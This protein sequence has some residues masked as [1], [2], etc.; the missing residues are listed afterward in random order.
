MFV[1]S[2]VCA[3]A[4]ILIVDDEEM[5]RLLER[6]CLEDAG[7]TPFFA[8]DGEA[9]LQVY[10]D[11]DIDVVVTDLRM[12]NLDGLQLIQQ[13]L[14]INPGAAV[15]AVSGAAVDQLGEAEAVTALSGLVTPIQ[16]DQLVEAVQEALDTLDQDVWGV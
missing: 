14:E 9:A 5:D 7:H 2:P 16:P 1:A 13:L 15:I 4:N 6:T 11:N 12:P 8:S 3:M 10:E